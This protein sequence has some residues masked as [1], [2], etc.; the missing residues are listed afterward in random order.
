ML[1]Q[2][3]TFH[4]ILPFF[5]QG[6]Q[7]IPDILSAGSIRSPLWKGGGKVHTPKPR[8]FEICAFCLLFSFYPYR[9]AAVPKKIRKLAMRAA[10][11]IK[12]A[13]GKLVVLDNPRL[14]VRRQ[15]PLA[16]ATHLTRCLDAQDTRVPHYARE[17]AVEVTVPPDWL[18]HAEEPRPGI[19]QRAD[20]RYLHHG[21]L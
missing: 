4:M 20:R 19:A 2:V 6:L 5:E 13:T 14:K 16:Y 18:H 9:H 11:S 1:V 10:L 17:A 7:R 3:C 15:S 21:Q 12:R 8:S